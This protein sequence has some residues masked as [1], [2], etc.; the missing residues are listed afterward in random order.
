MALERQWLQ[1][2]AERALAQRSLD[3]LQQ[4]LPVRLSRALRKIFRKTSE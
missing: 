4:S 2:E 1:A 3:M